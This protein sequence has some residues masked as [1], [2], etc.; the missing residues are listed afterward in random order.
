M[1][2]DFHMAAAEILPIWEPADLVTDCPQQSECETPSSGL[3]HQVCSPDV[4]AH[5]RGAGPAPLRFPFD[6]PAQTEPQPP[7]ELGGHGHGSDCDTVSV[8][9]ADWDRTIAT[10]RDTISSDPPPEHDHDSDHDTVSVT[11]AEW[12][13]TAAIWRDTVTPDPP[14]DPNLDDPPTP[15]SPLS[16]RSPSPRSL[17]RVS[18]QAESDYEYLF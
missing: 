13:H 5:A 14:P 4:P 16:L 8:T 15:S 1:N 11:S 3:S 6:E 18:E 17:M 7:T 9:S 12:N 10:L 2:S